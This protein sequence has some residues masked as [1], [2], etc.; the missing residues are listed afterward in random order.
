[1]TVTKKPTVKD[2]MEKIKAIEE[3]VQEIDLLKKRIVDLEA[4]VN[5]SKKY[6]RNKNNFRSEK[7][8]M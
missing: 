4:E 2:L 6:R 5:S 8:T 3:Q 1:M 7:D